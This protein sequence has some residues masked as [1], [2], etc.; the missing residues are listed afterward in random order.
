MTRTSEPSFEEDTL[1]AYV[2]QPDEIQPG[3]RFGYK[4]ILVVDKHIK[5]FRAYYGGTEKTD[6]QIQSN[7]DSVSEDVVKVLFPT[8]YE[9]LKSEK[10]FY[11]M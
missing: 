7:G 9:A 2:I 8:I 3:D 11:R 4:V 5:M 10:Y 1:N 6:N